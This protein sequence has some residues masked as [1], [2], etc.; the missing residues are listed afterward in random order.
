MSTYS[1]K[2]TMKSHILQAEDRFGTHLYDYQMKLTVEVQAGGRKCSQLLR[3]PCMSIR[4]WRKPSARILLCTDKYR[5]D[6]AKRPILSEKLKITN[7][8]YTTC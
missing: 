1:E 3:K 7:D 6:H 2:R 4:L 5:K 8:L